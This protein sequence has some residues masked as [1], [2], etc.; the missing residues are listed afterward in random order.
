MTFASST[1]LSG[2]RELT[3]DDQQEYDTWFARLDAPYSDLSF[4]NVMCWHSPGRPPQVAWCG[5]SL[6]LHYTTSFCGET[7]TLLSRGDD[8]ESIP[9]ALAYCREAL[10][11]T[12]RLTNVPNCAVEHLPSSPEIR[13]E[14]DRDNSDYVFPVHK[15]GR[16][17][18]RKNA[19]VFHKRHAVA[20]TSRP[21]RPDDNH[22]LLTAY[23]TWSNSAALRNDRLR[24][25]ALAL[26]RRTLMSAVIPAHLVSIRLGDTLVA[27]GIY[28]TPPHQG[29]AI[30]HHIKYDPEYRCDSIG[31][32]VLQAVYDDLASHG[33]DHLNGEQDLGIPGLRQYKTTL[34]P[35]RFLDRFT[36]EPA[37]PADSR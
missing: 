18:T 14:L 3:L 17:R 23:Q 9:A 24:V 11:D 37:A 34:H 6:L 29:W 10:P 21:L 5:E 27:F 16:S 25:E 26:D 20:V 28:T 2:L 1:T 32:A 12:P 7:I 31:D 13:L 35:S 33:I 22:E 30:G 19:A 36:V 4:T 15:N 8:P